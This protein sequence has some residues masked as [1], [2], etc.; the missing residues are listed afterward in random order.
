ME[1]TISNST[2]LKINAFQPPGIR[3]KISGD[4]K[5][6]KGVSISQIWIA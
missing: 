3:L 6:C 4:V 1:N 5:G 2:F